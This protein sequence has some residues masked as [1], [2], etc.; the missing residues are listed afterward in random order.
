MYKWRFHYFAHLSA[1]Y[2]KSFTIAKKGTIIAAV[3]DTGN[4][5]G[6]APHLHYEIHTL[7]PYIWQVDTTPQGYK[8]MWYI[9][10]IKCFE[11]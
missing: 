7:I 6:K 1:I 10:P 2:T 5:R 3:G 11:K 9:N 4:A 8:K